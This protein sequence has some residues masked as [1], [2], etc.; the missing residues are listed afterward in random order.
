MSF[1]ID[2]NILLYASHKKYIFRK[3][4]VIHRVV[5]QSERGV[6]SGMAHSD[7]LLARFDT[8]IR[9]RSSTLSR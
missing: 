1:A 4:Q 5:H 3:G 8:S 6:L 2:V 9:F 7:E